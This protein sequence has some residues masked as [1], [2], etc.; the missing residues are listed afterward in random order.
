MRLKMKTGILMLVLALPLAAEEC[1][2]KPLTDALAR[3]FKLDTSFY[4]K[5]TEVQGILIAT[6]GRVA[7]VAHRE[8]A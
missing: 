1:K 8:T 6:S 4:K 2:V 5:A 7:D 3:E